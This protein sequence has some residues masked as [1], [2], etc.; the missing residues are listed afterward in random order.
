MIKLQA[1]THPERSAKIRCFYSWWMVS[2][3][4]RSKKDFF[5]GIFGGKITRQ[6]YH[7][8]GKPSIVIRQPGKISRV[9]E[10]TIDC[11]SPA[12]QKSWVGVQT[13]D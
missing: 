4:K 5:C 12:R 1:F 10:E 2:V 7:L 9:A 3:I 6:K 11:C 13:H 8:R